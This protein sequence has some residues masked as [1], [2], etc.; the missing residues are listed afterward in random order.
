MFAGIYEVISFKTIKDRIQYETRLLDKHKDLIGRLIIA[1]DNKFRN[2]YPYLKTVYKDFKFVE[3]LRERI[4]IEEFPGFENVNIRFA[5]LKYIVENEEKSWK[6]ALSNIQGIYL[7]SDKSNGK[8]YVGAAYG[9]HAFWN[10]WVEYI[11]NGTGG[12]VRLKELLEEKG[13]D[14]TSNFN[15]SIL[16]VHSKLTNKDFIIQREKYWKDILLT[17]E[18]GYNLN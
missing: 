11:S 16:E 17:K 5:D 2:A 15:F 1:Y 4:K 6:S 13:F 12:N 18:F 7:I 8:L 14:H 3:I 9:E 10:R